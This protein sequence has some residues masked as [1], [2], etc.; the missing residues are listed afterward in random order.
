MGDAAKTTPRTPATSVQNA[1]LSLLIMPI[2]PSRQIYVAIDNPLL[3][4]SI[5]YLTTSSYIW[6]YGCAADDVSL[7]ENFQGNGCW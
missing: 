2:I 1:I 7:T 6:N 5:S 3:V 4:P